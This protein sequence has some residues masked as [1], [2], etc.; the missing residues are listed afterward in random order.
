MFG[1][2]LGCEEYYVTW[3]DVITSAQLPFAFTM[4]KYLPGCDA[5]SP[6]ALEALNSLEHDSSLKEEEHPQ[7]HQTEV[8][9]VI[10][11]P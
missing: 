7:L 2:D 11:K 4:N 1:L 5:H 8:P 10:Q 6:Q 3:E 9:V